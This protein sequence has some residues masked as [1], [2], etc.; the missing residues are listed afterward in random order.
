MYEVLVVNGEGEK[1]FG[2]FASMADAQTEKERWL[3]TGGCTT[4][5]IRP[6]KVEAEVV[7]KPAKKK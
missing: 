4:L 1:T 5:E 2:P 6:I 3:A 7:E